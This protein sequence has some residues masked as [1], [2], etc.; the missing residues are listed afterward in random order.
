AGW[1]NSPRNPGYLGGCESH[2]LILAP[3]SEE[4]VKVVELVE[5]PSLRSPVT[6]RRSHDKRPN[7]LHA[8]R[9]LTDG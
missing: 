5:L 7:P 6:S 4:D 2:H 3:S 1:V 8:C 9:R